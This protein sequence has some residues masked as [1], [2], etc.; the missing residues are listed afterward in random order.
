MKK[1][2]LLFVFLLSGC[3]KFDSTLNKEYEFAKTFCGGEQ[4]V[5]DFTTYRTFN[6]RVICTDGRGISIPPQ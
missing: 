6:S 5:L 3:F 1:I 2:V 4:Y